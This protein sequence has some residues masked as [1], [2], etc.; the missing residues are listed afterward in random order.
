MA[1]PTATA[2]T[3]ST[4]TAVSNPLPPQQA[5][6][7]TSVST[8]SVRRSTASSSTLSASSPSGTEEQL[9]K[10]APQPLAAATIKPILARS[11]T[12]FPRFDQ[13]NVDDRNLYSDRNWALEYDLTVKP[14]KQRR[15]FTCLST[16]YAMIEYARGSRV[17]R[18]N[19]YTYNDIDGA[20]AINGANLNERPLADTKTLEAAFR[21][22][23]PVIFHATIRTDD[24]IVDHY[25]LAYGIDTDGQILAIDP[26]EGADVKID[27]VS[28]AVPQSPARGKVVA[29]KFRTVDFSAPIFAMPNSG[30][31][32]TQTPAP[33]W[34][35]PPP[36]PPQPQPPSVPGYPSPGSTSA[37]G[38][39]LRNGSVFLSWSMVGG[40]TEY[41]LGVRDMDTGQ[42]VVDRRVSGTSYSPNLSAGGRYRWNVAA[43]NSAGCS[44]YTQPLYFTTQGS[45]APPPSYAPS[46]EV[47]GVRAAYTAS[48]APYRPT[49]NLSGAAL[50]TITEITWS[51]SGPN[52]G[53]S[54]WRP[55]SSKWSNF[56]HAS[57]GRS[58][59][60]QPELVSP[61]D[62]AGHYSW[63]VTFSAGGRSVTKSFSVDYSP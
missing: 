20:K 29:D 11:P 14:P 55:G 42:L 33:S 4:Q 47:S 54:I 27:P 31:Q 5:A 18:I 39:E 41:D 10:P 32:V 51:W 45:S 21:A 1:E 61:G 63:T 28:G 30:S 12:L 7:E 57:D 53:T 36:P 50:D 2:V 19:S 37:P 52:S 35:T 16:V 13:T 25:L 49:I 15:Y 26:L 3:T 60:V 59:T 24:K 48:S 17:Y 44:G 8:A 22:Y 38:P 23:N 58:A 43:C 46:L 40:A 6:V 34:Y 62:P 56:S 9:Q